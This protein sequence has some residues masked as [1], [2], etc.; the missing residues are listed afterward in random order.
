MLETDRQ[1][2]VNASAIQTQRVEEGSIAWSVRDWLNRHF[3]AIT[4][5]PTLIFLALLTAF[6]TISLIYY[7]LSRWSL[8]NFQPK[9][10]GLENYRQLLFEDPTFWISL[11]KTALFTFGAVGLEFLFGLGIAQLFNRPLKMIG[12]LR[13][14]IILPMVVTPVVTGLIWRIMYNPDFGLINYFLGML[15]FEPRAWVDKASTA[16]PALIVAD[17]WQWTPF[18][19]LLIYAGL[20]SLP[21][22]PFEAARVDGASGWQTFRYLTLPMLR[23]VILV[24]ILLRI[25]ESVK[26]FDIIFALTRGGPGTATQ[27]LNIYT[28]YLAFE[29]LKPGYAAALAVIILVIVTSLGEW[30]VTWIEPE[31]T[32]R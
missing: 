10:A 13:S 29:W 5:A 18:M 30:M 11:E 31:E 27:T 2:E 8:T 21:D 25:I 28:F 17:V 16:L 4:M 6:P 19:F 12:V 3:V 1:P 24:A 15:G 32:G 7:S 14:L 26:T 23:N 22:E 20:Q 9:W